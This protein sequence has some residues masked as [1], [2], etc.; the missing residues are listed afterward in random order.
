[1][2]QQP[3]EF[4]FSPG[5][6]QGPSTW[7]AAARLRQMSNKL[8][9]TQTP[10]YFLISTLKNKLK[11]KGVF[12]TSFFR[13]FTCYPTS[14]H[15]W[16]AWGCQE[17][18]CHCAWSSPTAP[19]STAHTLSFLLWHYQTTLSNTGLCLGH[20]HRFVS[21]TKL[22][23]Q[24]CCSQLQMTWDFKHFIYFLITTHLNISMH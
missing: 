21:G 2:T 13:I 16:N 3:A 18:G 23:Q 8:N 5:L 15:W 7:S 17:E 10:F 6:M 1:M 22:S 24:S 12:Q 19:R 14:L 9:T 4:L 11:E 20:S